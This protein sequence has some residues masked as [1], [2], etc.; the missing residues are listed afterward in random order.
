[1]VAPGGWSPWSRCTKSDE[2]D[3]TMGLHATASAYHAVYKIVY[4]L[5][6]SAVTWYRSATMLW[7]EG[8]SLP[9]ILRVDRPNGTTVGELSNHTILQ[10]ELL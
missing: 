7:P 9:A 3:R 2:A 4:K 6:G 10:L 5:G 1:V 8:S